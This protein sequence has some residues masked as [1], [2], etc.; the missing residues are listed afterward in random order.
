MISAVEGSGVAGA[1]LVVVVTA[2]L[3]GVAPSALW[4]FLFFRGFLG[5]SALS[6]EGGLPRFFF[7]G[8]ASPSWVAVSSP[9]F[10]P[11]FFLGSFSLEGFSS[12]LGPRFFRGFSASKNNKRK[13]PECL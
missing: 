1:V 12:P 5:L 6:S 4:A 8:F 9:G 13:Q 3:V 7:S 11:R 10:F 2:V